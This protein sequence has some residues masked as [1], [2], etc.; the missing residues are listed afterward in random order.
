M[1]ANIA[2]N[3]DYSPYRFVTRQ[4]WSLHAINGFGQQCWNRSGRLSMSRVLAML[5]SLLFVQAVAAEPINCATPIAQANKEIGKVT[6]DLQGMEKMMPAS[7][8]TE[9]RG[10]VGQANRL[11][12][13]AERSCVP[14]A[15]P[16][17][18]AEA[19]SQ[20]TSARAR[21]HKFGSCPLLP[22]C[23]QNSAAV[24]HVAMCQ[25]RPNASQQTLAI[26]LSRWRVQVV[27]AGWRGRA[28]WR[29]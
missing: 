16:Y 5:W 20:A 6:G 14:N 19:I 29:S 12:G 23:D 13:E 9:L 21:T 11:K 7:E 25:S 22:A 10:L 8:M 27:L 4:F 24:Q 15:S 3:D 1:I 28:P 26:R 2:F 17:Q 18:R